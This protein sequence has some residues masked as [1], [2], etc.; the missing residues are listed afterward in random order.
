M[1]LRP[2]T[3]PEYEVVC[4]WWTA[5]NLPCVPRVVLPEL[6]VIVED[7]GRDVAAGWIYFDAH[8][9]I[10]LVDWITTNPVAS[11]SPSTLTAIGHI[12]AFFEDTATQRGCHN[13]ISFVAQDTGLH[14]VMVKKGWQDPKSEPH[15]YLFKSWPLQ[16]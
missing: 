8:N 4:Q 14:R 12:L 10:G 3:A 7:E 6:G 1:R 16:H 9:H 13:L 5:R 15:V 11:T 2:I